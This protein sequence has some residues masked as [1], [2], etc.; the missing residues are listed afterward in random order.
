MPGGDGGGNEF[1]SVVVAALFPEIGRR[2][3]QPCEPECEVAIVASGPG[4]G[5]RR[6][7]GLLRGGGIGREVAGDRAAEVR[8]LDDVGRQACVAGITFP[9]AFGGGGER[10]GL[11]GGAVGRG[12]AGLFGLPDPGAGIGNLEHA[13]TT[14]TDTTAHHAA[15]TAEAAA[16]AAIDAAGSAQAAAGLKRIDTTLRIHGD[17]EVGHRVDLHDHRLGSLVFRRDHE[18]LVFDEIREVE[19]AEQEPQRGAERDARHVLRD[20]RFEIEARIL[21]GLR[22]DLHGDALGVLDL[23][24]HVAQRRLG[25]LEVLHRLAEGVVDLL[26]V[27]A[28]VGEVD[29]LVLL[30]QL[31]DLAPAGRIGIDDRRLVGHR[32]RRDVDLVEAIH[33]APLDIALRAH[34][35]GVVVPDPGLDEGLAG[36][37]AGRHR[38][39][40]VRE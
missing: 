19:I 9:S 38:H 31:R 7:G 28:G 3:P 1:G 39:R 5:V 24:D 12:A 40:M 20:G 22:V 4:R 8:G 27:A 2:D 36:E 14:A 13:A 18:H 23:R 26:L 33:E 21:E 6:V 32:D 11:C 25:E 15:A 10:F 16:L 37:H 30:A 34:V 29:R 35:F 17:H